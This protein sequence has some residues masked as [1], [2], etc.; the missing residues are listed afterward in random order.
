LQDRFGTVQGQCS[1]NP[2]QLT[3]QGLF[4]TS[5]VSLFNSHTSYFHKAVVLNRE[6]TDP[7]TEY[8]K[9][10]QGVREIHPYKTKILASTENTLH[11]I[12]VVMTW[13][14]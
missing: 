4:S 3:Q 5:T 2:F 8:V 10:H 13:N 6:S 1:H 12:L 7:P 11:A 14:S 9:P